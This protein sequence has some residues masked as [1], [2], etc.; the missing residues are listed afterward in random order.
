[1]RALGLRN[2]MH[3]FPTVVPPN[4]TDPVTGLST[5]GTGYRV[6]LEMM[7][8]QSHG[9]I[10]VPS[11]SAVDKP[12][13]QFNYLTEIGDEERF[14]EAAEMVHEIINAR[15]LRELGAVMVEPAESEKAS[16]S[17]FLGWMK[18]SIVSAKHASGTCKLGRPYDPMA[19]VDER[20]RVY[21]TENL[22]VADLSICPEVVRAPTNQTAMMIGERV[23]DLMGEGSS[24]SA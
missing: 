24:G 2:D 22:T 17:E 13:Q 19:V 15:P 9:E 16:S 23:A 10:V 12:L 1:M 18:R 8:A 7:R 14:R 4:G 6:T 5:I 20:G 21:G 3:I 11:S